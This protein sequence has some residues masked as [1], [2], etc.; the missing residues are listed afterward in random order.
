[1]SK[2]LLSTPVLLTFTLTTLF[3]FTF[4]VLLLTP[5]HILPHI[6]LP[7][8][9]NL[10]A[11][12]ERTHGRP[13]YERPELERT[14]T[15]DP[16][17]RTWES[18]LLPPSGGGIISYTD[19]EPDSPNHTHTHDQPLTWG[20]S[21]MHQLHC[22]IVLRGIVFPESTEN[23]I[24]STSQAHSGDE[25][26]DGKHWAHCFDY[27][28]QGI[29]CAADDTIERPRDVVNGHGQTVSQ[30]DGEGSVHQCRDAR[31][32]WEASM[33]SRDE[34][35]DLAHWREGVGVRAFMGKSVQRREGVP[36]LYTLGMK[37]R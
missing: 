27:I 2:P 25:G 19:P 31:V 4:T 20:I 13:F 32:L 21:M 14:T 18:L 33:A 12:P 17:F 24:N 8:C 3:V 16:G 5:Y 35:V 28:A 1:M 37:Q 30:I 29:L 11:N 6:L 36:Q 7:V 15:D 10:D 34:P 9:Q 26:H 23:K 22:L